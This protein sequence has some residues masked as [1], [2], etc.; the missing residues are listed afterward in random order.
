MF[1]NKLHLAVGRRCK[2]ATLSGFCEIYQIRMMLRGRPCSMMSSLLRWWSCGG[3]SVAASRRPIN[4]EGD[5]FLSLFLLFFLLSFL[6]VILADPNLQSTEW[7]PPRGL[8]SNQIK[9]ID[10]AHF[11]TNKVHQSAAHKQMNKTPFKQIKTTKTA[12]WN[13]LVNRGQQRSTEV[14]CKLQCWH[15]DMKWKTFPCSTEAC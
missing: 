9:F 2:A 3:G 1:K 6:V 12:K 4:Q 15:I 8:K 5:K 13:P 11:K 10:I 7:P 14:V